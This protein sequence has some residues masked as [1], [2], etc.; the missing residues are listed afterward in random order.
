MKLFKLVDVMDKKLSPLL[1]EPNLCTKLIS[2]KSTC[3]LC[4]DHCPVE[5][6]TFHKDHIQIED[7]CVECGLCTTVCPTSAIFTQRPSL[8]QLIDGIIHKC[9]DNKHVYL[10]CK[11]YKVPSEHAAS[12]SLPC[13]GAIPKEAWITLLGECENLSLY[14]PTDGCKS[15]HIKKGEDVWKSELHTAEM[16]THKTMDITDAISHQ[17]EEISFDR[18]RRDF[19]S[20]VFSEIKA[21]NKLALREM[22][23]SSNVQSYKEKIQ[24]D[25]SEKVKQHW[26]QVSNSIAENLTDESSYSYMNKQRLLIKQLLKN[27]KMTARKDI[28][29]P[30]ISPD[31]NLCGACVILCPTNAF[32]TENE[33]GR[34][35]IVLEPNKCIDCKLCEEICYYQSIKLE[36]AANGTLLEKTKVLVEK[37]E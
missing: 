21:T 17:E 10:H 4:V 20:A 18:G 12:I 16:I 35:R 33:N 14:L 28:R 24:Q 9:A 1:I 30:V 34:K 6:I 15:C 29:L 23:G 11:K 7:Q 26:E 36:A 13:F 3:N 22:I 25:P 31:C 32:V 19:F 5:C 8:H 37:S 27:E 2:P